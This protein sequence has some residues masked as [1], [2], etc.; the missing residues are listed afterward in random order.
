MLQALLLAALVAAPLGSA[1]LF[2]PARF[3]DRGVGAWSAAR[4][5]VFAV[6]GTVLLAVAVGSRCARSG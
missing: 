4:R 2:V 6:T 1:S 3:I 5:F